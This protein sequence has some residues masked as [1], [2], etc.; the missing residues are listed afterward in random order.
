ME[1][2][3]RSKRHP[4]A[5]ENAHGVVPGLEAPR[6]RVPLWVVLLHCWHYSS[7]Y[8]GTPAPLVPGDAP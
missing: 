1:P 3:S 8:G 7:R 2:R 6:G 5:G 4:R